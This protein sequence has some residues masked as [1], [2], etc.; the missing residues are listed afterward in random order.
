MSHYRVFNRRGTP[1]VKDGVVQKK[2]NWVRTPNYFNTPQREP[3]IDKR[4]PGKGYRHVVS[5]RD[6]LRFIGIIPRWQELSAGLNAIVLA[7]G[8]FTLNGYYMYLGTI[9][10]CAWDDDYWQFWRP[11]FFLEH[12][13]TL[14]R[15]GVPYEK[16][17]D[18]DFLCKFNESTV[19]GWQLLHIFLHELGHHHDRMTTRSRKV[20]ARGESY[21]ESYAFEFERQIWDRYR[22]EFELY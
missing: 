14:D 5:R 6:I 17:A 3:V 18:G 15:L 13:S 9:H 10:I 22:E 19:R 4:S 12:Q 11:R 16:D 2:S 8:C 21:A 7:E 20:C 1:K